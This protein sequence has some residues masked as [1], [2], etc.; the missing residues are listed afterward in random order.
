MQTLQVIFNSL[1]AA[2]FPS[3]FVRKN[4]FYCKNIQYACNFY[5]TD[6]Y[7]SKCRGVFTTQSNI[8]GG[9]MCKNHR[10]AFL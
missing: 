6:L 3:C 9:A 5:G 10:E 2:L 4:V 7:V 8:Y 1:I